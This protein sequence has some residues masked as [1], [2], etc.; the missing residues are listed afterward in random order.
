MHTK[1]RTE[2]QNDFE[3]VFLTLLNNLAFGKTTEKARKQKY[4]RVAITDKGRSCII[5]NKFWKSMQ[6]RILTTC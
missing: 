1:L 6:K 4:I 5:W 2:A 3:K